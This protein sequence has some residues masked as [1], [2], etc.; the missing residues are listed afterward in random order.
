MNFETVLKESNIESKDAPLRYK[1][2][3]MWC[4]AMDNF[5]RLTDE[6]VEA[7]R[8]AVDLSY[9]RYKDLDT[10]AQYE[11][12]NNRDYRL[13]RAVEAAI[14]RKQLAIG[15]YDVFQTSD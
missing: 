6:E 12:Q 5:E 3:F 15:V 11:I 10:F 2:Y 7:A 14:L 4:A 9:A 1:L 13:A 8:A